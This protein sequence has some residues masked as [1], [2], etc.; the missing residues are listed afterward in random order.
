MSATTPALV[1]CL[2]TTAFLTAQSP[3][4]GHIVGW[5]WNNTPALICS[6][7]YTQDIENKC[8]NAVRRGNSP[9]TQKGT[10]GGGTAYDPRMQA[11]WAS[12]GLEIELLDLNT[13][14]RICSFTATRAANTHVV[15]GLALSDTRRELFQLEIGPGVLVLSSYDVSTPCKPVPNKNACKVA[16]TGTAATAMGLAYDEARDLLYYVTSISGFG[17][18]IN[19]IHVVQRGKP[20][21]DLATFGVNYCGARPGNP[22]TG[23]GYDACSQKLYATDG[24]GVRVLLLTDPAKGAF[25]DLTGTNACCQFTGVGIWMGLDV[26]PN[27]SRTIVGKSCVDRPC[28]NCT[29]MQLSVIGGDASL[30][31]RDFGIRL[32]GAPVASQAF[33]YVALGNCTQGVQYGGLCGPIHT[34]LASPWPVLAGVYPTQGTTQCSGQVTVVTG[35]P[36]DPGLCKVTVCT[37]WLVACPTALLW[38]G[39]THGLQFTIGG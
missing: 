8:Q 33:F 13:S 10:G 31:N 7:V 39:L 38:H 11:A 2:F 37:Q 1:A 14:R 15:S 9:C 30:G 18:W 6:A 16:N 5:G 27:W 17:G 28:G 4:P 12:N 34:S 29:N 22:L 36:P 20:C 35:V 25:K 26:V 3:A 32:S 24:K 19:T 23:L 21:T